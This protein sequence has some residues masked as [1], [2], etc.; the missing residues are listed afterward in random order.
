MTS[1]ADNGGSWPRMM[2]PLCRMR[3]VRG[4]GSAGSVAT[5]PASPG[6]IGSRRRYPSRRTNPVA[7][8][9]EAPAGCAQ[10]FSR[11]GPSREEHN[12]TQ[13]GGRVIRPLDGDAFSPWAFTVGVKRSS[14][15][16]EAEC[17]GTQGVRGR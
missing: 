3:M 8:S 14:D 5:R 9:F 17:S 1:S 13:V 10:C 6:D 15:D 7:R 11:D 12:D 4:L 16:D 2:A